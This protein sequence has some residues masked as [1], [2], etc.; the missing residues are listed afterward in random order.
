M[1]P[2]PFYLQPYFSELKLTLQQ[3][4]KFVSTGLLKAK[5][6]IFTLKY[7]AEMQDYLQQVSG[8]RIYSI[9]R[10]PRINAAPNQK[11]AA[12]TRG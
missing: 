11:N 8:Y 4:K 1:T 12:F 10:R 9:N 7:R 5:N 6:Y 3:N 2:L